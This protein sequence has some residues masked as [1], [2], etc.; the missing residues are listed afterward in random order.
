[1]IFYQHPRV[2][3]ASFFD[4]INN[5]SDKGKGGIMVFKF[6]GLLK[7][8]MEL[9]LAFNNVKPKDWY[10]VLTLVQ[11]RTELGCV[12]PTNQNLWMDGSRASFLVTRLLSF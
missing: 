2:K 6:I 11:F 8:R 1:M 9:N 12:R 5:I 4:I 10:F 3:F 7:N